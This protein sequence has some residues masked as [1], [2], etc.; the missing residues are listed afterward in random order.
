M[1]LSIA[2]GFAL[3][4]IGSIFAIATTVREVPTQSVV[5]VAGMNIPSVTIPPFVGA[6]QL[7]QENQ[8]FRK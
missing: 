1:K 8:G 5:S 6:G 3:V 4:L 7:K 2:A